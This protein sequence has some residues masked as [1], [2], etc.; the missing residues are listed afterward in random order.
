MPDQKAGRNVA[1]PEKFDV[2]RF[3]AVWCKSIDKS[4]NG[5]KSIRDKTVGDVCQYSDDALREFDENLQSGT[6]GLDVYSK[7]MRSGLDDES[8]KR[9][10][11]RTYRFSFINILLDGEPFYAV[12]FMV[13]PYLK[14]IYVTSMIATVCAT[15]ESNSLDSGNSFRKA[16]EEKFGQPSNKTLAIDVF[17]KRTE[18]AMQICKESTAR[19]KTIAEQRQAEDGC[20]V[21]RQ[22]V[23]ILKAAESNPKNKDSVFSLQWNTGG[24]S[25]AD[26]HEGTGYAGPE[27]FYGS[28]T[29]GLIDAMLP[30]SVTAECKIRID[31][32]LRGH[33]FLV[34]MGPTEKMWDILKQVRSQEAKLQEE[35]A[36][37]APKPKL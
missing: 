31:K 36:R 14:K 12:D 18:A 22:Q 26:W 29:A 25:R 32:N 13:D 34:A 4:A 5:Q 37:S 27:M 6:W 17:R 35:K 24:R 21:A 8:L 9:L 2:A 20:A 30:N 11:S 3:R 7:L 1:M 10:A 28:M 33:G 23:Q 19:A 16:L 15:D